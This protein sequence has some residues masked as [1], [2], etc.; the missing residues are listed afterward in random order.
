MSALIRESEFF[1]E[2]VSLIT[3]KVVKWKQSENDQWISCVEKCVIKINNNRQ[4]KL[5]N[6]GSRSA[7]GDS[8]SHSL[9]PQ[10]MLHR[11]ERTF[12]NLLL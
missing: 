5:L 3:N 10:T 4:Q 8:S 12:I 11:R 2:K 6:T 1:S 7:R 9:N